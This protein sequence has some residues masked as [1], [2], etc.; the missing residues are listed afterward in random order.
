M[1]DVTNLLPSDHGYYTFC[2]FAHD[3][4]LLGRCHMVRPEASN[5]GVGERNRRFRERSIRTM[6][7]PIQP[8]NHRKLLE[9]K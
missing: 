4:T 9:T 1:V 2:G 5:L 3:S 8:Q 7:V 6:P